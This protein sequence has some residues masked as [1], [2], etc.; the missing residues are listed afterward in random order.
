MRELAQQMLRP[1]GE[2][3]QLVIVDG[4]D[5]C[6]KTQVARAMASRFGLT[7][8]KNTRERAEFGQK[9][10]YFINTLRYGLTYMLDY[11]RQSDASVVFDRCYPTEWVY[12]R[13]FG[14]ETD[15]A[16]LRWCDEEFA[17]LGGKVIVLRRRDYDGIVDDTHPHLVDTA[18]LKQ[19]DALYVQFAGWSKAPV[20]YV[21]VDD[22]DL[23]RELADIER[24]L[25]T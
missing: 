12:A 21:E 23:D 15:E 22:E 13:A 25:G 20:Y 9:N 2:R 1:V 19:L 16:C 5:M 3:G 17:R 8:F 18:R 10:D 11:L 24:V 7:Y 14:R 6:G 4:P